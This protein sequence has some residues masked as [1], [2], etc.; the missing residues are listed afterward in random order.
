MEADVRV[1]PLTMRSAV[2][3]ERAGVA[4]V[5]GTVP[6]TG[7][8]SMAY[9]LMLRCVT[10]VANQGMRWMT[11]SGR[12]PSASSTPTATNA[13]LATPHLL[14][15][16]SLEQGFDPAR[17]ARVGGDE[18]A[19]LVVR[20][21]RIVGDG[22]LLPRCEQDVEDDAEQRRQRPEQDRHLEHDDDVRRDRP[23]GLA[24]HLHRP[25]VRH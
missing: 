8:R 5:T 7:S 4:P 12:Q 21:P 24:S 22:P 1:R 17:L 14:R 3:T 19:E 2:S 20:E 6:S 13:R 16:A 10:M 9:G 15:P 11:S 23:D 25:V 18:D